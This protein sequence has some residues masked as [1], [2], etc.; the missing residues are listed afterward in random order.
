MKLDTTSLLLAS[1]PLA[2]VTAQLPARDPVSKDPALELMHL[3]FDEWPTGVAVS[4]LGRIFSCCL[5][6]LDCTNTRYQVAELARTIP[7][8]RFLAHRLIGS[9]EEQ[10][11]IQHILP[12]Q[13]VYRPT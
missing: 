2:A 7:R 3:Y 6:G 13:K 5:L 12:R 8:S 1:V 11:I 9:G 10:S 4:A